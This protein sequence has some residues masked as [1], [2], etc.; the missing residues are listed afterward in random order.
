MTD[1][2][3]SKGM[4]FFYVFYHK[5]GEKAFFESIKGYY[6]TFGNSGSTTREFSEYLK[7][8]F[9]SNE[10]NKLIND[11]IFTSQS[12]TYLSNSENVKDLWN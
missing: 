1:F 11:W 6:N 3:Y 9:K 8:W 5:V 12:T 7:S 10:V 4:L 2:S